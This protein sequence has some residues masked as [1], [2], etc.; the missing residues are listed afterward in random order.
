[1][2]KIYYMELMEQFGDVDAV[3]DCVLNLP[4]KKRKL[5]NVPKM[6]HETLLDIWTNAQK[7]VHLEKDRFSIEEA[8]FLKLPIKTWVGWLGRDYDSIEAIEAEYLDTGK[9]M[10]VEGRYATYLKKDSSSY[11][12]FLDNIEDIEDFLSTLSG[13]HA[14]AL[15]NLVITFSD[16][17]E[18]KSK[19]RYKTNEDILYINP[20]VA[21]NTKE[22]YG[23]LR[24]IILHEL[25]HRYLSR[26]R[27]SWDIDAKEF[28]TT[29]YSEV[30]TMTGEERFAELYALSHWENKYPE[31]AEQIDL[32]QDMIS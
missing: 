15:D 14:D 7:I 9:P 5:T 10:K 23:S 18:L 31:Y 29:K 16:K 28:T 3:V 1:M 20:K 8:Q 19:A 27:Q 25:G 21:G 30:E 22:E 6:V 32:F 17:A 4:I 13:Y 2:G 12:N 24:Y 11:Q 26:N